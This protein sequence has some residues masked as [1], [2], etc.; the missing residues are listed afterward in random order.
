MRLPKSSGKISDA[1]NGFASLIVGRHL[2]TVPDG[3]R[4]R[5]LQAGPLDRREPTVCLT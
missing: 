3:M 4:H 2:M 1:G 5:A